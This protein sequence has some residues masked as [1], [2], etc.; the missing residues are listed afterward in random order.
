MEQTGI[1][2][3]IKDRVAQLR[4]ES[5]DHY[6]TE[7]LMKLDRR[8]IQEKYQL[9]LMET[10]L[11][12][13]CRIYRQRMAS[14]DMVMPG[15]ENASN[16]TSGESRAAAAGAVMSGTSEIAADTTSE[17]PRA[18]A[19]GEVMPGTWETAS[20]T[21]PEESRTT[22]PTET[23]NIVRAGIQPGGGQAFGTYSTGN[24]SRQEVPYPLYPQPQVA[25]KPRKNHEFT[26]GINVFGSIGVLFLL[27]ALILL[28]IN[29][30][31]SM[32]KMMGLYALG[33]LVWGVAEFILKKKNRTLSMI[34]SALGIGSLYVTTMV[35]FLYLHN[36]S[37]L[38]TICITTLVTV[39]LM[40]VSRKKDAG[41]LRIICTGACMVSF[42]MMDTLHMA[43]DVEL[44]VYMGMI[45]LVQLLG[46]FLPVKQ[47]AYGIAIG[48]MAGTAFFAWRFAI[49]T[50]PPNGA[51]ELRSLYLIGFVVVSMLLMELTV[52]RM[53]VSAQNSG[54]M[55]GICITFG[56]G[57]FLLL[58]A[59]RF[60]S[61]GF[62]HLRSG[63]YS[64]M[65]IWIRMGVMAALAVM[66]VLFFFL[67][68]KKGYLPWMQAYFV[69]GAALYLFGYA[70]EERMSVTIALAALTAVYKLMAFRQKPLWVADAVI[71][72]WTALVA[73]AYHD[74]VYG[75]VLL[76]VLLLGIVLMNHWQTY[77]E[78]I[79]TG[80]V[81]VYLS[82]VVDNDLLLPLVVAVM[83]LAT[84]L[85][86][87]VK[88]F[89]GNGIKGFNITILVFE[90][91]CYLG[92][93][94]FY[95][96]DG[97]MIYFIL[98]VL[99]LGILL[100]TFQP[101]FFQRAEEWRGLAVAV[102]LTYMV[103]VT[104]FEY[105][106]TSSILMMVVGLLG[107]LFGF[108]QTDRKLR[109]YGLVLCM[110]MCFKITLFDFRVQSLQRIILFLAAGV[111]A[112]GISG[113]YALMDKKYNRD[114]EKAE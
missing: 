42:L 112:L 49:G 82:M 107:I 46:I 32:V 2:E 7:Y 41:I 92:L 57:M 90:I 79:L 113:V 23:Q 67:T 29:Y 59:Y 6:F 91:S 85:F 78:F 11:E 50:I 43:S 18:A 100:F 87:Y 66:G 17:E 36:F 16:T 34:F 68:K 30:M 37:G 3:R 22:P 108:R 80:T 54:Q 31:S 81:V 84:L 101:R 28:G 104:G 76:G 47:W 97:V 102:F 10:E 61:V 5:R 71:T 12:R 35:N 65:E 39:A 52:W 51:M 44:L 4:A 14:E 110:L 9:D 83:W 19:T 95:R 70:S 48:Q 8:L 94:F 77:Y 105:R 1:Y 86:N 73:L 56:M 72:T 38:V 106:I 24:F 63:S 103:L 58:S 89:T 69:A 53:P 25:P 21:A 40:I 15:V 27:A 88:R 26:I 99:G 96:F 74:T 20:D 98:T 62:W 33:L 75:Y 109:L 55:Q 64:D 111:V 60:C 13:S 114:T 93:A 45:V